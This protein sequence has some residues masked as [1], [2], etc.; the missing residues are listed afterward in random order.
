MHTHVQDILF[1]GGSDIQPSRG[2]LIRMFEWQRFHWPTPHGKT[3]DKFYHLIRK[4]LARETQWRN[5]MAGFDNL[6]KE[7]EQTRVS[8]SVCLPIEPYG[9]TQELLSLAKTG[10][11]LIPFASV[12][13]RDPKRV[14]KLKSYVQSGCRGLKLHPIIQDFHPESRECLEI[15]EEFSQYHLPILFHSGRTAYYVP[16]SESESFAH[17]E[18]YTKVLASFPKTKFILGH[19]GM[20]EAQKAIEM[21]QVLENV[22]LETSLQPIRMVRRA[23][24]KVGADRILFGSDWPFGGQK[25]SLAVVMRLTSGDDPLRER[26]LWQNALELIGPLPAE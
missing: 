9:S 14:E 10:S 25:Y 18:N 22:Y 17:L 2:V 15:V 7:M 21:A 6:K 23:V 11:G 12:D 3:E 8:Y 1:S 20:F 4:R 19:M 26:L 5:A 24:E 13:P 16:E